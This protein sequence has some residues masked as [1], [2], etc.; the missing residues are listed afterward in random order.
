MPEVRIILPDIRS[1]HNVGS[2]LRSAD[3]FGA[4]HIYYCGYTPY[5]K[6]AK[7]TRLP[8]IVNKITKQISKTALGAEKSLSFSYEPNILTLI[9][10]LKKD[11]FFIAS[12]EQAKNSTLLSDFKTPN[13]I[14]VIFGNEL[15][16]VDA[17]VLAQS[18]IVL[19]IPL[20]GNKES[21][22]VSSTAAIVLYIL[23]IL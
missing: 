19:E 23:K 3:C 15:S 13:K 17:E 10:S 21:L 1:T 9:N 22:N 2:I 4:S 12:I 20:L 16:G 18:D 7:D 11:G 5:P 14:A 8:H 6:L